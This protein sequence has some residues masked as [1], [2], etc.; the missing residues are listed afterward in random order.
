MRSDEFDMD[1]G[2]PQGSVLGPVL[3]TMYMKP[4]SEIF[5]KNEMFFHCYADDTQMY[6]FDVPSNI[7]SL[8]AS[9][10]DCF[11]E[12]KS[13]MESNKMKLN[14]DK[15]EVMLCNRKGNGKV[16]CKNISLNLNGCPIQSS[17]HVKNLGVLL[18]HDLSMDMQVNNLC[19]VLRNNLKKI[20]TIR[21]YLTK[22]ATSKLVTTL[23]LSRLDYCNSLLSNISE[24]K[25]SRLQVVQNSAA[26]LVAKEK[27]MAL[28]LPILYELHWLPVRE[29]IC[30][31]VAM[32]CF[33]CL[34]GNAP[35]YLKNML[36]VYIPSRALRSSSDA[37][38]LVPIQKQL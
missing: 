17:T 37:T 24:D 8:I 22:D 5:D 10:E 31:K 20:A 32:L 26:K 1:Y 16:C 30:F 21:E 34:D 23:I 7:P 12:V 36:E 2:V 3:F 35:D 9:V 33:K 4:L 38:K 25:L 29:R 15:T 6:R 13:W 18:E 19:R 14:D 27:R 28:S 11:G